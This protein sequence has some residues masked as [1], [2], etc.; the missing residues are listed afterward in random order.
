MTQPIYFDRLPQHP[1]PQPLESFS[2]YLQRIAEKNG[3]RRLSD[4]SH[5]LAI[6]ISILARVADYTLPS[7]GILTELSGCSQDRLL[8]MTFYHVGKKFIYS[9]FPIPLERFFEGSFGSYLRYC[10]ACL[11]E[12]PHYS[13]LWRFLALAGC[14]KHQFRLLE[15]CGHCGGKIPLFTVPARVGICPTCSGKLCECPAEKLSELEIEHTALRTAELA[16]L[17]TPHACEDDPGLAKTVGQH[18]AVLR[19]EQ[20]RLMKE[21]ADS[22]GIPR[23][24]L[25]G[26]E[27]GRPRMGA[28]FQTYLQYA[29]ALGVSI[30]TAFDASCPSSVKKHHSVLQVPTTHSGWV[31]RDQREAELCIQA[32]RAIQVCYA[33]G[34][35]VTAEIILRELGLLR[36]ALQ[37]L[38]AVKSIVDQVSLRFPEQP[39]P[40]QTSPW[41]KASQD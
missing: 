31:R 10:P 18:W 6:P 40:R 9:I 34:E 35:P 7:F 8:A 29:D 15:Q 27:Q 22:S 38:P 32:Q 12:A 21:V 14:D 24:H 41:T 33:R 36:S 39:L 23:K 3:F 19:Y 20:Q 37:Y 28:Y 11:K 30:Q 16:F 26:I 17:V 4:L 5:L 13:L 25:E 2:S 1:Q